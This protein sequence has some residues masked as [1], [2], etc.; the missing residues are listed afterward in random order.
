MRMHRRAQQPKVPVNAVEKMVRNAIEK[1]RLADLV[2]D[3]GN[4][5]GSRF[6]N[7]TLDAILTLPPIKR[8]MATEQLQ[9][10]FVRAAVDR[11]ENPFR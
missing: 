5:P 9:S 2:F 6:L 3:Q 11:I 10:R 4:G 8:I 7:R 1:N